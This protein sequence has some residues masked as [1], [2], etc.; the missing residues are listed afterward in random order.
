[1]SEDNPLFSKMEALLKKHRTEPEA[2]ADTPPPASVPSAWLPVLTQVIERGA[3]PAP[4]ITEPATGTA[5]PVPPQA[6]AEAVTTTPTAQ[7]SADAIAPLLQALV[8]QMHADLKAQLTRDLHQRLDQ[9]MLSFS[10]ELE[11]RLREILRDTP[12]PP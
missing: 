8:A 7:P 12:T 2:V 10:S 3:V 11:T 4:P 1:M 9:A 5:V 6:P